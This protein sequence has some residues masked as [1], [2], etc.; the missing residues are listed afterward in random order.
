[1]STSIGATALRAAIAKLLEHHD[2][3]RLRRTQEGGTLR[4]EYGAAAEAPA[5][6]EVDLRGVS[7]REGGA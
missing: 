3:L 1:M 2:C 4:Q 7:V 5:F 6:E